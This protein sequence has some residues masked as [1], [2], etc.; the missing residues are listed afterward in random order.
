VRLSGDRAECRVHVVAYHHVPAAPGVVDFCT[1]R[2]GWQ[3]TLRKLDGRCVLESV[4]SHPRCAAVAD[5][6]A[7][8]VGRTETTVRL[9]PISRS[10][11]R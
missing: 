6:V 9:E 5:T 10:G 1:M 8:L 7:A 4:P 11:L 3:L 2:G